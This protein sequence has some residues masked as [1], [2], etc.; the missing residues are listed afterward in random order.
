MLSR[1]RLRAMSVAYLLLVHAADAQL[2][3]LTDTLLGDPRSKVYVHLDRKCADR[4]WLA[5]PL[6]PRLKV[7]S[8][9]RVNWAGFSIV[10]ATRTL[11]RAAMRDEAN[12][13]FALLSGKC[14]PLQPI[15]EVNDR[16][17]ATPGSAFALWGA[18]DRNDDSVEGLGRQ[19][20]TK[21]HF[22]DCEPLNLKR[23]GLSRKLWY[24]LRAL[25]ARLPYQ[26]RFPA[27]TVWKG[28]QFFVMDRAM[29]ALAIAPDRA[30]DALFR[31]SNA[32]DEMAF[33]TIYGR[34]LEQRGTPIALTAETAERQ[35]WHFIRKRLVP[36]PPAPGEEP[37]PITDIRRLRISDIP[38]ARASGALFAR[39]CESDVCAE[40]LRLQ[41]SA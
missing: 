24:R 1:L 4:G 17:L 31:F 27:R 38:A 19:L 12:E 10:K 5:G 29:A 22:N 16:L 23:G 30:L 3:L 39:K 14:F 6:D 13:R 33:A 35:A 41:R 15:A 8:A 11:L 9:H 2:R 34:S 20:I 28:S 7:L 36:D 26:R 25:N 21:F 18:I 40:I 37:Q 32:P